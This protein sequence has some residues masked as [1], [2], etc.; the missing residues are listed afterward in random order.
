MHASQLNVEWLFLLIYNLFFGASGS[1]NFEAFKA[2]LAHLWLWII[3]IGYI[4]AVA[5]L[6]LI[7]YVTVRIFE[8][9][10]R[11]EDFY[12]T[13]ITQPEDGKKMHPRWEKIQELVEEGGQSQ[14]REAI[15]E[16]E[17]I[18]EEVLEEAGYI[19]ASVGDKLK[20][21]K[22]RP[23]ATLQ[24]AWDA[25]LVRNQIAHQGSTFDLSETVARRTL[26]HFESVF[27]EFG[28]I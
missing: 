23:F 20:S 28:V 14:W 11:E 26:A 2:F 27:R 25:H 6:F 10:K 15:I 17:I 24:D 8:L 3:F 22:E 4:L 9:R 19:G 5:G 12:T 16:A 1:V 13:L 18:L 21:A 7:V